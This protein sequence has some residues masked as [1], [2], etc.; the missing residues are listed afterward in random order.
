EKRPTAGLWPGQT[1]EDELG[2][3]YRQLDEYI[4]SGT[5]DAAAV[6]KIERAIRR[7]RHKQE[8]PPVCRL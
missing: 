6:E 7:S 1:D 5:T 2:F 3:S 4:L 8:M